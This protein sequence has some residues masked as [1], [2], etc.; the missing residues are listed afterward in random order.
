MVSG[1][2][3]TDRWAVVLG[4]QRMGPWELV[5]GSAENGCLGR[6]F[7][8]AG[9]QGGHRKNRGVRCEKGVAK[10]GG[11]ACKEGDAKTEEF[12]TSGGHNLLRSFAGFTEAISGSVEDESLGGGFG[13]CRGRVPGRCFRGL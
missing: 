7:G 6:G 4:L 12:A 10:T 11:F 5:S 8:V 1:S 9:Q 2:A 3:G 13:V